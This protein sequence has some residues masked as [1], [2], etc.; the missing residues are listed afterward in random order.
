M[1]CIINANGQKLDGTWEW[2]NE[3]LQGLF[4]YDHG[5]YFNQVFF[6][7]TNIK[8]SEHFSYYQFS[9][10]SIIFSTVPF[11]ENPDS[12]TYYKLMKVKSDSM[13]M[14]DLSTQEI[15]RYVRISAEPRKFS[16]ANLDEFYFRGGLA[17]VS[18]EVKPDY[19]NCLNFNTVGINSTKDDLD[20][21]F[22]EPYSTFSQNGVE[23]TIYLIPSELDNSPYIA[24]S[25]NED[26]ELASI[27]MTGEKT[28]DSFAFSGIRL[29][30]YYTMV[31]NRLGK[32]RSIQEIDN[33]TKLWSYDPFTISIEL[34]DDQVYSIKLRRI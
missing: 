17:C 11:D 16:N 5:K 34:R 13:E 10:D 12:F 4:N 20:S 19:N 9:G 8:L 33:Q 18:E 32:A 31:E 15:D 6:K 24:V 26:G 29:G 30:D 3:N 27:Q 2:Q 25:W 14:M 1:T 23:Y 21:T 22:G 7:G 28:D